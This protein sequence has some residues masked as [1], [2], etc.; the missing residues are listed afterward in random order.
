MSLSEQD[1]AKLRKRLVDGLIREGILTRKEIINAMLKVPRHRFV[2]E[3]VST[4][5]YG[6][7]PMGIG[8]GQTI[9]APHMVAIMC[10][11]L[12]LAKGQKV[13]EIGSGSGYH[14]AV[15]AE[16]V[17]EKGRVYSIERIAPLAEYARMNIEKNGYSGRVEIILGDGSRGLPDKSPFDRIY[18]TAAS[19]S[20]PSPLVGQLGDGGVLLVPVGEMYYQELVRVRKSDGKTSQE[21]LGGCIFVPLIGEHGHRY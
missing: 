8:D 18:V 4:D 20:I 17:G 14:A 11:K 5:A 19:P 2:P 16:I 6:D 3:T 15:V 1:F 10:E 7:F 12:E 21:N 13:L 9:S